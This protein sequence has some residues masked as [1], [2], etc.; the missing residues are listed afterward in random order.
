M[1]DGIVHS[2]GC[3]PTPTLTRAPCKPGRRAWRQPQQAQQHRRRGST[4]GAAGAAAGAGTHRHVLALAHV[5]PQHVAHAVQ[6]QVQAVHELRVRH[7]PAPNLSVVAKEQGV[8]KG[9]H[10]AGSGAGSRVGN[11]SLQPALRGAQQG[12]NTSQQ[13]KAH[14]HQLLDSGLAHAHERA[15]QRRRYRASQRASQGW[16][17]HQL[18]LGWRVRARAGRSAGQMQAGR[19]SKLPSDTATHHQVL[20][21]WLVRAS[22]SGSSGCS[23][24]CRFTRVLVTSAQA[25]ALDGE[26]LNGSIAAAAAPHSAASPASW[27]PLQGS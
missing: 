27:S 17:Y 8:G 14:H 3:T 1:C 10:D 2:A 16:T 7:T 12:H 20:V 11:G 26:M 25:G 9:L 5:P 21:S 24:F 4:G 19:A 6:P 15:A 23:T 18:L 13:P 22:T